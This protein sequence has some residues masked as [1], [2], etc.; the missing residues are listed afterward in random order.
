MLAMFCKIF[1]CLVYFLLN[2]NL[3]D[4]YI[5]NSNQTILQKLK[6]I[7]TRVKIQTINSWKHNG[8]KYSEINLIF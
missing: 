5:C 4:I 2:K 7:K 8:T 1:I 3:W 6:Y